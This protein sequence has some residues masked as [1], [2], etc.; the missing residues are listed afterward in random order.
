MTTECHFPEDLNLNENLLHGVQSPS[1][2]KIQTADVY[3]HLIVQELVAY[4]RGG[5]LDVLQEPHSRRKR[6]HKLRINKIKHLFLN[7]S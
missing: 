6:R 3:S 2:F 7:L 4:Y 1:Q 5:W